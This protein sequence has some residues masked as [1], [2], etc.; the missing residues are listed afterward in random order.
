MVRVLGNRPPT[1]L[2][3]YLPAMSSWNRRHC[4]QWLAEQK[5]W[6]GLTRETLIRLAGDAT[7]TVRGVVYPVL[8]KAKLEPHEIQAL[9]GYLSRKSNDVRQGI[10]PLLLAQTDSEAL[11][12]SERLLAASDAQKR[13]AGLEVLRQLSAGKRSRAECQA[14]AEVYRTARRKLS[15]EEQVQI[16]GILESQDDALTLD[17]GLGLFDPSQRS[18]AIAPEDC[19]VQFVTDAVVA[20]LRSL[21]DLIHEHRETPIKVKNWRGEEHEMLLGNAGG[22]FPMPDDKRSK[23]KTAA[24]LP[25]REAWERWLWNRP[26]ALRDKDGFEL[27]RANVWLGMTALQY[28]WSRIEGWAKDPPARK[29]V[30]ARLTGDRPRPELKYPMQVAHVVAWLVTLYP[31]EGELDF[32]LDAVETAFAIVPPD[33]VRRLSSPAKNEVLRP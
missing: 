16:D 6:D 14:R 22:A 24:T 19:K 10:L 15:G 23:R 4:V 1:A 18:A 30:L 11:A 28:H 25:L 13:L 31:P 26:K 32:L 29:A 9:E 3:P 12:S 33:D 20:C 21:D 2:I 27:T 7:S 5:K 17:N 8:A